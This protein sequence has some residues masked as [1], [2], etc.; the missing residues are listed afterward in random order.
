MGNCACHSNVLTNSIIEQC[1][2]NDGENVTIQKKE[3]TTINNLKSEFNEFLFDKKYK[4]EESNEGKIINLR[5]KYRFDPE[6]V[7]LENMEKEGAYHQFLLINDYLIKKN[8]FYKPFIWNNKDLE[9]ILNEEIQKQDKYAERYKND[10]C[11]SRDKSDSFF[12]CNN[13]RS[14]VWADYIIQLL[15]RLLSIYQKFKNIMDEDTIEKITKY[16]NESN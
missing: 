15:N 12:L 1:N 14:M 3:N 11:N 8:V 13:I 9:K 4:Y 7:P 5:D 10:I 16:K 2:K 6:F